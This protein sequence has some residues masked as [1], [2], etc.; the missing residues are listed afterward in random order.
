MK[1]SAR[2]VVILKQVLPSV[3]KLFSLFRPAF[4]ISYITARRDVAGLQT[5]EAGRGSIN[6]NIPTR[7]DITNL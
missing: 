1:C 6:C 7:R 2:M 5:R 3:P 4:C